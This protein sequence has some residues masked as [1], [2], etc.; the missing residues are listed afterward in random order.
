[1][2]AVAQT[3]VIGAKTCSQPEWTHEFWSTLRLEYAS[4]ENGLKIAPNDLAM[5]REQLKRFLSKCSGVTRA[6]GYTKCV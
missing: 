4:V 1:M 2:L 3:L 6:G 5:K